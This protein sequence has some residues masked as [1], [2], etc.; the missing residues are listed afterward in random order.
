[1]DHAERWRGDS[2][3]LNHGRFCEPPLNEGTHAHHVHP[4]PDR[5]AGPVGQRRRPAGRPAARRGARP[6]LSPQV[7]PLSGA[8]AFARRRPLLS[9]GEI[10]P[11]GGPSFEELSGGD[12]KGVTPAAL[13]AYYRRAGA[14]P[15][16]VQWGPRQSARDP[17]TDALFRHL[18]R[19]GDGKL[20]R[21]ELLDA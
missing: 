8:P 4:G 7:A 5:D 12:K 14:G 16:Q 19:N 6:R 9:G 20:S 2:P 13:R 18:D 1:A 10:D 11:D 15:L 21:E 17:L 3:G